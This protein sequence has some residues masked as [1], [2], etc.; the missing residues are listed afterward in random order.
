MN[1]GELLFLGNL[2]P[3]GMK[4]DQPL[5]TFLGRCQA[6]VKTVLGHLKHQT[7]VNVMV[8][9]LSPR[10]GAGPVSFCTQVYGWSLSITSS[11]HK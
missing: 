11:V 7:S 1:F 8:I 10:F 4:L 3:A 2:P 5:D 9:K 6:G